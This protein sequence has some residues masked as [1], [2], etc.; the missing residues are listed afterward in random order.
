MIKYTK[1]IL[2]LKNID[3]NLTGKN[4]FLIN[5]QEK[6]FKLLK[7][8]LLIDLINSKKIY[9]SIELNSNEKQNEL[10]DKKNL[11]TNIT[12]EI[13][14]ENEAKKIIEENLEHEKKEK[15]EKKRN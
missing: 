6:I 15:K 10:K 2:S 12:S 3:M 4:L 8:R 13:T 7:E 11:I 5:I 9:E 1:N 14:F